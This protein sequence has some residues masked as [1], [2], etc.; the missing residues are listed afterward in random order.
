MLVTAL[1]RKRMFEVPYFRPDVRCDDDRPGGTLFRQVQQT[2]L[3]G[4]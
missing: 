4:L 2:A 1:S 3:F